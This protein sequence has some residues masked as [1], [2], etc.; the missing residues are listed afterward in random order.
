[1]KKSIFLTVFVMLFALFASVGAFAQDNLTTAVDCPGIQVLDCTATAD[2]ALNPIAGKEYTYE[3]NVTPNGDGKYNWFVTTDPNFITGG[4][5]TTDIQNTSG[6]IILA[7]GTGYNDEASGTKTQKLTWQG[8]PATGD[9]FLVIHYTSANDCANDNLKAYK[10]NILNKFAIDVYSQKVDGTKP[11]NV[12]NPDV[13]DLNV[14]APKVQG[15]KYEGDKM[16]YDYGT[17]YVYYTIAAANF[18]DKWTLKFKVDVTL[19]AAQTK[20]VAWSNDGTTGWNTP[21][22]NAGVYEATI[23]GETGFNENDCVVV[24]VAVKNNTYESLDPQ[25]VTLTADATTGDGKIK[26]V[27]KECSEAADFAKGAKQTITSRPKVENNTA[28]GT[29]ILP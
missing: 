18:T 26:D 16:V 24:R 8:K 20:T 2:N 19:D 9:V 15:A 7:A 22:D 23:T 12:G 25:E 13:S 1:M 17:T 29:F 11:T 5:L 6:D 4:V 28:G 3:V 14:C 10:I 21:T 27:T